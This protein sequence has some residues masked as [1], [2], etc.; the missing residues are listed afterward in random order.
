MYASLGLVHHMQCN[1]DAQTGIHTQIQHA[2]RCVQSAD[3]L[4]L[5]LRLQLLSV[6]THQ[7]KL[8]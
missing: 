8:K 4:P 1:E 3:Y 2:F 5:S 6:G 7:I